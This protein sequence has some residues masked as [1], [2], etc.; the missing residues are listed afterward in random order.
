VKFLISF[1]NDREYGYNSQEQTVEI[2][3]FIDKNQIKLGKEE[4]H[5]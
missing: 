4:R 1:T 5:Q 3:D 2:A